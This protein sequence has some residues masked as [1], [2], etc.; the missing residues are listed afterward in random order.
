MTCRAWPSIAA[1]ANSTTGWRASP[2]AA[3]FPRRELPTLATITRHLA[4]L[5]E[6]AEVIAAAERLEKAEALFAELRDV[7]RLTS[8]PHRPV[9]HRRLRIDAPA[10]AQE[11]ESSLDTWTDQLR[12]RLAWERDADKAADLQTVLGYLDKYHGNLVG[13]VIPRPG[14]E[15]PFVVQRTNNVS[16][17]RFGT[18]KQGLRRKVGTKKLTRQIQ[19]MRPEELL[20]ANLDDPDYLDILCGGNLENLPAVFAQNWKAAQAIR[21][22]RRQKKTNHPLP[23]RK[24]T[25]RASGFLSGL[26]RTVKAL[27]EIIRG[28]RCAA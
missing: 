15:E 21:K 26:Q 3:D 9:L 28:G 19:A 18:T 22:E 13:H 4:P 14:R 27:I 11:M 7:L 12:Q 2:R 24:R 25:L 20:V 5:R 16:E 1:A 17:H 6:D 23:T 8:D 10:V